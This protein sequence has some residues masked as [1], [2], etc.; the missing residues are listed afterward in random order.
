MEALFLGSRDMILVVNSYLNSFYV[1]AEEHRI[2]HEYFKK[3][4]HFAERKS[5]NVGRRNLKSDG[6]LGP[7]LIS[8]QSKKNI[9]KQREL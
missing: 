6:D 2:I 3:R 4:F 7:C 5:K 1:K 9:S 8:K